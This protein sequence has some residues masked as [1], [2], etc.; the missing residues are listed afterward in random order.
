MDLSN[1]VIPKSDQLNAEDLLSGPRTVTITK[2]SA[3]SAEQPVNV[4]LAEIDRPWR[5]SKTSRRVLIAAWGAEADNYVGKRV[6][7]FRDPAIKFGGIAVGG[8]AI[9][10]LS[11]I[12]KEGLHIA[13]TET[14]GKR[15][16]HKIQLLT[17]TKP[18][19]Q[20]VDATPPADDLRKAIWAA[21]QGDK[22]RFDAIVTEWS[23]AHPD[24]PSMKDTV[25]V[26]G[27][28]AVLDGVTA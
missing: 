2:V 26:A 13:L 15:T 25:D 11:D 5:P 4:H 8:I 18:A 9:S 16:P 27:L 7:L 1:T 19:A 22:A 17:D 28:Q 24:D 12:P 3:G 14:R 20:P 23:V 6:T 21:C 10:H